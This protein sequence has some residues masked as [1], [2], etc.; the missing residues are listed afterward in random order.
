[1]SDLQRPMVQI[2]VF[3]FGAE[4][5]PAGGRWQ[6]ASRIQDSAVFV[7]GVEHEAAGN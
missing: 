3:F 4:D 1:M 5:T 7:Q 2:P 6:P